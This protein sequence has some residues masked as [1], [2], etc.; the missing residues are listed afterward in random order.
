MDIAKLVLGY[1]DVLAWP[2]VA[3]YMALRYHRHI[4]RL[5][6]RLSDETEELEAKY[7]GITAKFHKRFTDLADS[8]SITDPTAR[9]AIRD[10]LGS[11]AEDQFRLLAETLGSSGLKERKIAAL[12]VRALAG[13]LSIDS[14]ITFSGSVL[15]GERAGAG[16]A[17]GEH[18]LLRPDL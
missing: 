5:F 4:N 7:F 6:R 16:I 1:I 2:S 14:V 9:Q 13:A 3:L 18:L 8:P 17:L 15:H 12:E 11:L 10:Q